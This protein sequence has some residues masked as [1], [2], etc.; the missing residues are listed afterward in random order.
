[1]QIVI[2]MAGAGSR[3][4]AVGFTLPKPLI[5]V[6]GL[7]MVVRAIQALPRAERLVLLVRDEHVRDHG[8]DRELRRHLPEARIVVVRGDSGGQAC[9]VRLALPELDPEAPVLVAACDNCHAYDQAAL[10]RRAADPALDC[11]VWTFR[12]DARVL[13]R[14]EGWGWV[15]ADASGRARRISCKRVLSDRPLG[16][17]AVTGAF[18]FRSAAMMAAGIDRLVADG[19]RVNGEYYLDLVPQTMLEQGARVE[20]FEVDHYVGW[21]TPEDLREFQRWERFFAALR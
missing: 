19:V 12:G 13:V 5:P 15:D 20:V 7:P 16:D 14:P 10:L 9:T 8:I 6:A 3:F 4:A 18:W 2:P 21:G 1:M 11:L 17:H